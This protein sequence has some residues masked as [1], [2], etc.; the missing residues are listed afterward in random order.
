MQTYTNIGIL[1]A[2]SLY[3]RICFKSKNKTDIRK[4][5]RAKLTEVEGACWGADVMKI[6]VKGRDNFRHKLY[7]PYKAH[8]PELEPDMKKALTY[9]HEWLVGEMGAIPADG[10]EADDL[11]AIWAHEAR[12]LGYNYTIC[13]ID[14]DLKQIPGIHYNFVKE[15]YETITEDEAHYLLM[16]QALT[17]DNA[18]GIPGLRGIGP[19]KAQKILAGVPQDRRWS[20][21]VSTW[22]QH[23]SGDPTLS[24]VLLR[25]LKTWEDYETISTYLSGKPDNGKPDERPLPWTGSEPICPVSSVSERDSGRTDG[26]GVAIREDTS[27]SDSTLRDIEQGEGSGQPEQAST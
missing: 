7:E 27:S 10:M 15:E 23:G 9:A 8:R 16:C 21:V 18:D 14:K 26:D 19:K 11:V 3:F 4:H 6:A 20:T 2:D 12:E 5:L 25:M 24:Y 1:D 17:G 22:K 13:G